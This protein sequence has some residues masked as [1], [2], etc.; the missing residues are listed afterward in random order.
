MVLMN[1]IVPLVQLGEGSDR[2]PLSV[3]PAALSAFSSPS[4]EVLFR[5]EDKSGICQLIAGRQRTP[6]DHNLR[7]LDLMLRILCIENIEVLLQKVIRQ[8][9][10]PGP[11]APHVNQLAAIFL[12]L[13]Q[14][15]EQEFIAVIVDAPLSD[16]NM[17]MLS[18]FQALVAPLQGGEEDSPS[19]PQLC[20]Q[21]LIVIEHLHLSR[22]DIALLKTARHRIGELLHNDLAR[23]HQLLKSIQK[24]HSVF[25]DVVDQRKGLVG[26]ISQ[27]GLNLLAPKSPLDILNDLVCRRLDPGGL[28]GLE[29]LPVAGADPVRV[30]ADTRKAPPQLLR[31]QNNLRRGNNADG[32]QGILIRKR[33]LTIRVEEAH[34]IHL[35]APELNPDGVCIRQG[36]DVNNPPAD[37]EFPRM[38]HPGHRLI[39]ASDQGQA[40]FLHRHVISLRHFNDVFIIGGQRGQFIHQG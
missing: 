16:P 24:D 35:V 37:S 26:E 6:G 30:R 15:F 3:P 28:L 40:P 7:F 29:A 31:G 34:G 25:G 9:P 13:P 20:C 1:D 17:K 22:Q 38:L 10:G 2:L 18:D 14:V 19:P 39:A 23:L 8:T 33:E 11:G 36:K 32:L 27:M 21:A 12:V 5:Q 4:E